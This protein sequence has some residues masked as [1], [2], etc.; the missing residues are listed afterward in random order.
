MN[1]ISIM[2]F[3]LEVSGALLVA[4]SYCNNLMQCL[5]IIIVI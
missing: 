2:F 1:V 4:L 3:V 5:I